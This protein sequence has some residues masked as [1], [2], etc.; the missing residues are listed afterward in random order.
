MKQRRRNQ[1][2]AAAQAYRSLY[3]TRAWRLR[4]Q[5]QLDAEP[6]CCE[7][8]KR[9]KRVVATVADHITPH[10]GNERL[11]FEG[12]LASLCAH[13]HNS[14]KQS[15]ERKTELGVG[16]DMSGWPNNPAHPWNT[17]GRGV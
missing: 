13:H 12:D 10:K 4:R 16:C 2:S 14:K 6:W 3:N 15:E 1:R 11:F 9:G 5:T 8:A 17:E 7:C